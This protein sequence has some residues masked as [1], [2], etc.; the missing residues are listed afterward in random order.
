MN[1]FVHRTDAKLLVVLVLSLSKTI[2]V[3]GTLHIK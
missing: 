3:S 1:I 2:S